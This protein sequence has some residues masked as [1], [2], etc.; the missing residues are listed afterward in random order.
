MISPIGLSSFSPLLAQYS[1]SWRPGHLLG[2]ALS[3][4]APSLSVSNG[5]ASYQESLCRRS[6]DLDDTCHVI[7]ICSV[8]EGLRRS[9]GRR[10]SFAVRSC[11]FAG[12]LQE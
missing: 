12:N 1:P 6:Q 9:I 3:K 7:G 8:D 2:R 10:E 5:I 11:C 4:G